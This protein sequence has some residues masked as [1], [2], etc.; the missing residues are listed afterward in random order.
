M[1][2]SLFTQSTSGTADG[3]DCLKKSEML[4]SGK[5]LQTRLKDCLLR[6]IPGGADFS[7]GV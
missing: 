2:V 5:G 7:F 6:K 3:L 1:P 4:K